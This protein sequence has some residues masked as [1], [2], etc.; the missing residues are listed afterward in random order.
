LPAR[1]HFKPRLLATLAT[2]AGV[3]VTLALANWQ[4]GRA[5]EKEALAAQLQS[6][7]KDAPVTLSIAAVRAGASIPATVSSSTIAYATASRA[8]TS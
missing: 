2:A 8:I 5:H 7:A 1:F 6:R 4:L 3:A